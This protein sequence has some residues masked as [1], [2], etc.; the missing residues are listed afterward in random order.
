M[1]SDVP[2]RDMLSDPVRIAC[3]FLGFN[4]THSPRLGTASYL[5]SLVVDFVDHVTGRKKG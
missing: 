3:L 5:L 1:T 2:P 4:G